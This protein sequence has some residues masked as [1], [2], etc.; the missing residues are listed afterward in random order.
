MKKLWA[1]GCS[2]TNYNK[3]N[4]FITFWPEIVAKKLNIKIKNNGISGSSNFDSYNRLL[5]DLHLIKKDDIVIFQF[6]FPNRFSINYFDDTLLKEPSTFFKKWCFTQKN[7]SKNYNKKDYELWLDFILNFNDELLLNDY[8]ML[9]AVFNHIKKMG[10]NV[11]YYFL[12][13]PNEKTF[14]RLL[15]KDLIIFK[16]KEI[17]SNLVSYIENNFTLEKDYKNKI[18]ND[19]YFKYDK[20]PNQIGHNFFS[21]NILNTINNKKII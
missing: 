17:T 18:L 10:V 2:W 21:E 5:K 3:S 7:L 14:N 8:Y 20:H 1:Y 19:D 6:T 12:S 4:N 9:L 11:K 16:N 13:I 15:S